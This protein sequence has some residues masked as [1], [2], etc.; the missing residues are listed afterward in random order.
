MFT[1]QQELETLR[2]ER[3]REQEAVARRSREDEEELQIL[4][5]RCERLEEERVGGGQVSGHPATSILFL[6]MRS[7]QRRYP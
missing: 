3:A 2:Q 7:G 1:L 4:R 5:E 6:K